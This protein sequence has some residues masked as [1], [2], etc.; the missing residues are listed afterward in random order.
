M[1]RAESLT[2]R[3]RAEHVAAVINREERV[4]YFIFQVS[5]KLRAEIASF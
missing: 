2:E 4:C 5:L 1:S 3:V